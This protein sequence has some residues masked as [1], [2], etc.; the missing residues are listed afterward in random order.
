MGTFLLA[1]VAGFTVGSTW[2]LYSPL[3][4]AKSVKGV[5]GIVS[6]GLPT[7]LHDT[8]PG[9]WQIGGLSA[10]WQFFPLVIGLVDEVRVL[11]TL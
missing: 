8:V 6:S 4:A 9:S 10:A 11:V 7:I 2:M 5:W 1:C 3:Q